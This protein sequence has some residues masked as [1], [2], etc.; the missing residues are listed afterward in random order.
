M[1]VQGLREIGAQLVP[2]LRAELEAM[3]K[4]V[5]TSPLAV[6]GEFQFYRFWRVKCRL[7]NA[8]IGGHV[9]RNHADLCSH[10]PPGDY[11]SHYGTTGSR[12]AGRGLRCGSGKNRGAEPHTNGSRP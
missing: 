9:H 5:E 12:F 6:P 1:I 8:R 10:R 11:V 4:L 2:E 7:A 3:A